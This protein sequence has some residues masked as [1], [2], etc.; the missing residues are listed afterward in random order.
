MSDE[1]ATSLVKQILQALE[2]IKPNIPVSL[3]PLTTV[4]LCPLTTVSADWQVTVVPTISTKK[5]LAML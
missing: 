5:R 3:C 2:R 4:S 1:L